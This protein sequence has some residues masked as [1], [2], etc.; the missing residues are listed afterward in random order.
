MKNINTQ[1][2]DSSKTTPPSVSKPVQVPQKP[3][4]FQKPS[5]GGFNKGKKFPMPIQHHGVR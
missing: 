5:F 2:P 3:P 1:K 4:I